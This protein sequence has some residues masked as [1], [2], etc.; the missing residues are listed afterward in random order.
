MNRP[1]VI[2]ILLF[3][4]V[5]AVVFYVV[6]HRPA[7]DSAPESAS[8][9]SPSQTTNQRRININLYFT[10][11]GSATLDTEERSIP[12]HG[13][14]Q[15]QA[16]EVMNALIAAPKGQLVPTIPQGVRL[17][18]ILVSKDGVAYVDLSGE[19]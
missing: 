12:Y 1:I 11:P 19:I 9:A 13:T 2:G 3:V 8:T 10:I 15:S 18:D 14:L 16:K 6:K 7:S 17:I 4:I 5:F